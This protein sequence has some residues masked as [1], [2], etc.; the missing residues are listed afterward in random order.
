MEAA[1][2]YQD[3]SSVQDRLV[4]VMK[5]IS[6]I[7]ESAYDQAAGILQLPK[8]QEALDALAELFQSSLTIRDHYFQAT[9][10]SLIAT[11]SRGVSM[12]GRFWGFADMSAAAAVATLSAS[13]QKYEID[14][15]AIEEATGL[16]GSLGTFVAQ[17]LPGGDPLEVGKEE[18]K[19]DLE[20]GVSRFLPWIIGGLVVLFLVRKYL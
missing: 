10:D 17:P 15:K 18:L 7:D 14:V 11:A 13:V 20:I 4:A 3:W 9:S 8:Q 1:Q 19:Q 2:Q 6:S 5:R 16:Q 12:L